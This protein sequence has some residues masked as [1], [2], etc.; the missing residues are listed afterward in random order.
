MT[1]HYPDNY[2]L[3]ASGTKISEN[4]N[5]GIITSRWV[6]EEASAHVGF[7]IGPF[8]IK[9]IEADDIPDMKIMAVNTKQIDDVA[10]ELKES[11]R[12][13]KNLFGSIPP[14]EFYATEIPW[15]HGQSFPGFLHLSS[16]AFFSGDKTG[17]ISSFVAHEMAHQWWGLGVDTKTYHDAW[18]SEAFA[19]YSSLMFI[20]IYLKNNKKF[21]DQLNSHKRDL[22]NI[23]SSFIFG[24]GIEAGP[25]S[26]G[27]RNS[28]STTTDD[29]FEIIYKKGA[30]VLH[31]LRNMFLDLNTMKEDLFMQ[32]MK[33]FYN[34]YKG[35]LASTS[36]FQKHIESY[37]SL[38]MDW[39]FKQWVHSSKIP[40]YY[41]AY[42]TTKQED[43]KFI[44][45]C[46]IKQENV[47]DDF[48]MIIPIKI[49]YGDEKFSRMRIVMKGKKLVF[50]LPPLPLKP[51]NIF[52]NDLESVL[53]EL[54]YEDFEDL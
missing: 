29:Y 13:Y 17:S 10:L 18:I 35:S 24:K 23:R 9:E 33:D 51:Q 25:I 37:I 12:F 41:F 42:N 22:L 45:T 27:T 15:G 38:D 6:P 30:W 1:F 14:R 2:K 19:E 40:K 11:Y 5:H 21:F 8:Q 48:Q 36:D 32:I 53:C 47:P 3:S 26:L 34:K 20:Q 52:F 44:V 54:E 43:G 31:M 39:F 46:K 49:D 4:K 7:N 28:T 50:D 16:A